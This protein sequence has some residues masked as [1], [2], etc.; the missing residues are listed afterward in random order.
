MTTGIAHF[1]Q[2]WG[3]WLRK[4]TL[5]PLLEKRRLASIIGLAGAAQIALTRSHIGPMDCPIMKTTGLPCPP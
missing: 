3:A 2:P 5:T 4:P 1:R